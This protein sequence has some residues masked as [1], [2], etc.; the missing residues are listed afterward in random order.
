[1]MDAVRDSLWRDG[2]VIVPDAVPQ[3][4]LVQLDHNINAALARA[5]GGHDQALVADCVFE[6]DL[7]ATKRG[8]LGVPADCGDVF[9]LGNLAEHVPQVLQLLLLAKVQELARTVLEADVAVPHFVNL[10]QKSARTGSGI[11]WHRDYPN[12]YICPVEPAMVRIMLCLDGMDEDT[13]ATQFI[14]GSQ[15]RRA[16]GSLPDERSGAVTAV[17][18]PGALVAIHPLVLHGG[19]PNA[20]AMRRRNIVMQWGPAGA[21]LQPGPKEP[22][23]GLLPSGLETLWRQQDAERDAS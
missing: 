8:E 7:P 18:G 9:I 11:S 22:V 23:T 4:L 1:M 15:H 10:T 3:Q 20:S 21:A 16:D 14:P 17:C 2:F 19:A 5:S 6:R 12:R 13:G